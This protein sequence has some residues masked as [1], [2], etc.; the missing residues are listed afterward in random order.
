MNLTRE[1]RDSRGD[2]MDT[3]FQEAEPERFAEAIL[4]RDQADLDS[5]YYHDEKVHWF[6]KRSWILG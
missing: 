3:D 4:Y 6:S 5:G 1:E 2:N